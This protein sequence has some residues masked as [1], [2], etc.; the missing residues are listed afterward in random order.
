MFFN[1]CHIRHH[2][3]FCSQV[4]DFLVTAAVAVHYPL[5]LQMVES[6]LVIETPRGLDYLVAGTERLYREVWKDK[7]VES[8]VDGPARL[9]L[10]E[11]VSDAGFRQ[12]AL[13]SRCGVR[14][15]RGTS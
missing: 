8:G 10:Y 3:A 9:T 5:T 7:R 12:V 14:T 11:K 1:F 15:C 13:L 2:Y 6:R 4:T